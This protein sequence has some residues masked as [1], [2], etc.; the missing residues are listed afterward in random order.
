MKKPFKVVFKNKSSQN[1]VRNSLGD[2][3]QGNSFFRKV[4]DS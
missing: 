2:N 1:F 4:P 3:C